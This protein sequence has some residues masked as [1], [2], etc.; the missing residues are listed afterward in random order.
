LKEENFQATSQYSSKGEHH[1]KVQWKFGISLHTINIELHHIFCTHPLK[2]ESR[3]GLKQRV[4]L[5][6]KRFQFKKHYPT[7][8]RMTLTSDHTRP[9]FSCSVSHP[10]CSCHLQRDNQNI[11]YLIGNNSN[12]RKRVQQKEPLRTLLV[13]PI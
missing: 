1:A 9:S 2:R 8:K 11:S 13:K 12:K 5:H 6:S 10:C 4:S 3:K 7:C